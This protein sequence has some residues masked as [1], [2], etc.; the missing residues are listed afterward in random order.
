MERG[1]YNRRQGVRFDA[2]GRRPE[3]FQEFR[4]PKPRV[5]RRPSSG[6]ALGV[7]RSLQSSPCWAGCVILLCLLST[8]GAHLTPRAEAIRRQGSGRAS[9]LGQ[10]ASFVDVLM[11]SKPAERSCETLPSR[12]EICMLQCL[13]VKER[14]EQRGARQVRILMDP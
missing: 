13:S 5:A 9:L 8:G 2:P 12:A 4:A 14:D 3:P 11:R 7:L 10:N 1:N 6:G